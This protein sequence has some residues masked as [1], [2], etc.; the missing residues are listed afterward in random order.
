[1]ALNVAKEVAAMQLMAT[2]EL[3]QRYAQLFGELPRSNNRQ[4][5]IKRMAW[6]MQANYEGDLSERARQRALQLANDADLRLKAPRA[7][8][9]TED[10]EERTGTRPIEPGDRRLPLPGTKLTR[11]YKDRLVECTVLADGFLCEGVRY[12]SLSAVARA[13]TGSHWNGFHFFGL[14]K[15]GRAEG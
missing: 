5:M 6:R 12:K 15:N 10:G 4:W 11:E 14:Q 1:M 3:K 2:R 13:V 8:E 7:P 9:P